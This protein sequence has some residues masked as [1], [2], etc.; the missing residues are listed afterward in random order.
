[1]G[2]SRSLLFCLL[3]FLFSGSFC[4]AAAPPEDNEILA[5]YFLVLSKD[6]PVENFPLK[7]TRVDVVISGVIAHVTIQQTYA[8]MGATPINGHYIFPGSTRAAVHGMT[9]RR[10]ERT[11][12]A[13]IQEK[14]EAIQTF[15][16]AKKEGKSSS[17]LQQHRP[18]VFSMDVAN[19]MPGDT[20]ELELTYSELLVPDHGQYSFVFP[21]VVGP[22]YSTITPQGRPPADQWLKN[23]YLPENS[24]PQAAFALSLQLAT[25]LPLQDIHSDTHAIDITFTGKD[26]A[27]IQLRDPGPSAANR[28]LI[29]NYR[30]EGEQIASGLLLHKGERENYF[31]FM[32]QPPA[33]VR[34]EQIPPREYIFIVDVS[35]SMRGFPLDLGKKMIGELLGGLQP[36]DRFNVLLFAG[37]SRLL[38]PQSLPATRANIDQAIGLIDQEAGGGATELLPALNRAIALPHQEA[39]A[40]TIVVLTDGYIAT[41]PAIFQTITT[42][43][44]QANLFAFGIGTSVN[45]HLIEQMAQAGQG[46]PFVVT[47]PENAEKT[48]SRFREY[49]SG[50][51]LTDIDLVMDGFAGTELEP[52][53]LADLFAQRPMVVFGK[54]TGEQRGT[55][56]LKGV[57]GEGPFAQTVEVSSASVIDDPGLEYLWARA[58][59]AR[60]AF[61]DGSTGSEQYKEAITALGLTH[62]LLTRYTS[63]VAVDELIRNTGQKTVDVSQPLPLPQGVSNA[64]IATNGFHQVPEPGIITLLLLFFLLIVRHRQQEKASDKVER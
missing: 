63:F 52:P 54:W 37:D 55:I 35:G 8:N 59:V 43:L 28:D 13:R 30:L 47:S 44:H 62:N 56:T 16:Q 26:S 18:N 45:R 12:T 48:A 41:E 3:T 61:R 39:A 23:P 6:S 19:I 51:V 64:A 5:P 42:H 60:L 31:L 32:A 53:H 33:L 4:Q 2:T 20:I 46:E 36:V 29:V 50:P 25:G 40:R 27:T 7:G 57:S 58:R 22:R 11:I 34:P 1:M 38:A 14:E 9:M 21:A 49:I 10:G 17:L 24:P 15:E